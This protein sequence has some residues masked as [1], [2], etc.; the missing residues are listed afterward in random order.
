MPKMHSIEWMVL[1]SMG[2]RFVFNLLDMAE[3]R[4]PTAEKRHVDDGKHFIET[5]DTLLD[6]GN[7]LVTTNDIVFVSLHTGLRRRKDAV[8]SLS[9]NGPVR[10][11]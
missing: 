9:K 1:N 2:V 8:S 10:E 3:H 5:C 11:N 4:R 7:I 6:T